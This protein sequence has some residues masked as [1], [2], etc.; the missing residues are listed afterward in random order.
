MNRTTRRLL[1]ACAVAALLAPL[2]ALP[3]AESRRPNILFAFADEL[4]GRATD[5]SP[6]EAGVYADIADEMRKRV[7]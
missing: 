7:R 3:A 6:H 4:D 2:A 1:A 5:A